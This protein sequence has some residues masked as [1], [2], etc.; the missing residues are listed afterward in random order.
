MVGFLFYSGRRRR[1]QSRFLDVL[2]NQSEEDNGDPI[3]EEYDNNLYSRY[4][5]LNVQ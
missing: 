2:F 1:S 5:Y 3:P 4:N